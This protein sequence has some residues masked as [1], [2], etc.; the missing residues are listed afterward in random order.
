M[1]MTLLCGELGLYR[2]LVNIAHQLDL[3]SYVLHNDPYL[4]DAGFVESSHLFISWHL[5]T[6]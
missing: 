5:E 6:G 3:G 2:E 4:P 1:A